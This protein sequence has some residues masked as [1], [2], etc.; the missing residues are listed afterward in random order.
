MSKCEV[1]GAGILDEHYRWCMYYVG[2]AARGCTCPEDRGKPGLHHLD[3]CPFHYDVEK[4]KENT[5]DE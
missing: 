1:C 2:P 4:Y 5:E 3:C